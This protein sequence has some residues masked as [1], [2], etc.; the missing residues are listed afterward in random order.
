[1]ELP[2]LVIASVLKPVTDTIM[3][4][5]IGRSISQTKKYEGNI[6]GF[7]R[8]NLPEELNIKF[9]PIFNFSRLSFGRIWCGLKY[10]FKLLEIQP[11]FIIC[12]THELL[13]PSV[14]YA[15]FT[16]TKVVYDVQENYYRNILYTDAFPYGLRYPIALW[17]RLK[18]YVTWPSIYKYLLA[19]KC[20]QDELSF[21]KNKNIVIENKAVISQSELA[22]NKRGNLGIIQLLF[23]GTIAPTTGIFECINLAKSLHKIDESIRLKIE[24]YFA[25]KSTLI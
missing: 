1:M 5:K 18:E 14:A 10:F 2:K 17:V 3:Y 8:K 16:S 25:Q 12:S 7:Y 22:L 19:E 15:L 23:S 4:E 13:I 20:Y 21:S 6:I 9:H 11:K 24:D